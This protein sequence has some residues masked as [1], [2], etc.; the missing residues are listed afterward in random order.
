M[1]RNAALLLGA[2]LVAL[3]GC[4]ILELVCKNGYE[5]SDDLAVCVES[6]VIQGT[7][8]IPVE[9]AT[10]AVAVGRRG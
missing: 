9:S 6:A 10:G 3:A 8:P 4:D 2:V 5:W 1:Q 7:S